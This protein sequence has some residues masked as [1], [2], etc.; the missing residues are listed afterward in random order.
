ML[1]LKGGIASFVWVAVAS[2]LLQ[3]NDG[4][5]QEPFPSKAVRI[6]APFSAGGPTD[7]LARVISQ[8]FNQLWK[9][10]VIVE[11][12]PGAG[13]NIGAELVAKAQPDGHTLLISASSVAINP[14]VYP[15]MPFD[16]GK[17]LA[18]IGL[19]GLVPNVLVVHPSLPVT[20]VREFIAFARKNPRALD[21]G[22]GGTGTGSHLIG[23]LFQ[24]MT[25]TQ[26]VHIPYKGGSQYAIALLAGEVAVAFSNMVSA[27]PHVRSG[28]LRPLGVTSASRSEF[29][30][31]V[32][33]IAE[34]GV[35]GFEADSWYGVFTT[36]GTPTATVTILSDALLKTL[37]MP[38]VRKQLHGLGVVPKKMT[39][40]Q[41]GAFVS[42]E[43]KKWS[44]VVALSKAKVR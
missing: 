9:Q 35:P 17:D 41:F 21:Y 36:G 14:S 12:R 29:L 30:P 31:K 27:L 34:S 42:S 11:N 40:Q 20:S 24:S 16:T 13:G 38:D 2:G 19:A 15:N 25:K 6:V 10:P 3:S 4:F 23:E 7:L 33:T 26:L 8:K 43:M 22:S 28:K 1:N 37:D 5:A 18:P 32:P 44:G 39:P